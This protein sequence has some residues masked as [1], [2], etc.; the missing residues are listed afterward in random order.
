MYEPADTTD[1][2]AI[3][4]CLRKGGRAI[5][6][7]V[8]TLDVSDRDRVGALRRY[9]E[10]YAAEVVAHH[11]I[12]DDIFFPALV[13]RAPSAVELL[14]RVDHEHD[15][16]DELLAEGTAAM[17]AIVEGASGNRAATVLEHLDVLM[18]HHLAYEDAELLPMIAGNFA[19]SE[20]DLLHK[21]A[22]KSL[23]FGKQALFAVPFI[24]SWLDDDLRARLLDTA[25][26]Q[27]K[28]LY[29][30][31]RRGHE[32]LAAQA[33]G[34]A[35]THAGSPLELVSTPAPSAR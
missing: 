5:A 3:H 34:A 14:D 2:L 15:L 22:I 12:E 21:R 31:T 6:E 29:R 20:Y 11:T 4:T 18:H 9:W 8:R 28:V 26:L 17:A 25:P 10:G 13:E 33:L 16:L 27:F 19:Q 30:V 23:G 32:R 35:R 24:G 7:A 1:Y